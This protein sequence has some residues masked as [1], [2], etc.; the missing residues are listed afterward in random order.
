MLSYAQLR[1][2]SLTRHAESVE[3]G[4]RTMAQAA[5]TRRQRT[6][7]PA[8]WQAALKRALAE[9]VQVRQLAG[10]GMWI[11]TSGT[12]ATTAYEVSQFG[13]SCPAG[14]F[15]DPVCKHRAAYWHALGILELDDEPEP[16]TPAAPARRYHSGDGYDHSGCAYAVGDGYLCEQP[17]TAP[18]LPRRL[19]P[20]SRQAPDRAATAARAVALIERM[21][22]AAGDEPAHGLW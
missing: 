8:R 18:S 13:C 1:T 12:D 3:R 4:D 15:G 6:A 10:S 7:N 17:A 21:A 22:D 20:T 19:T 5:M 14:E 16:P 11:A 2:A 9:G